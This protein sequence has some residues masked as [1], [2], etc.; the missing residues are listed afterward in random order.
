MA[1]FEPIEPTGE[2]LRLIQLT[3]DHYKMTGEWPLVDQL[4]HALDRAGE[5]FDVV[6]SGGGLDPA[7]GRVDR[8]YQGRVALTLRGVR[9]C[10]GS[11]AELQAAL[12]TMRLAVRR[13]LHDG[14]GA[15]VSSADV[16]SELGLEPALSRR[17]LEYINWLPGIAGGT[18]M[19][20]GSWTRQISS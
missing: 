16:E 1:R 9:R 7:L 20:D 12:D 10:E 6:D 5:D 13:W 2:Q 17:I 8:G 4:Q 3:F 14:P 11:E 18:G 19:S 15:T